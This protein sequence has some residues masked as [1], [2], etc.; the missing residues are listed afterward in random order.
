MP[1]LDKDV[2][3][4]SSERAAVGHGALG[5]WLGVRR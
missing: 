5:L 2:L 4:R 3:D 1:M